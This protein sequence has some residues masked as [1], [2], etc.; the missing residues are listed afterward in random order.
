MG[1]APIRSD[2][3]PYKKKLGHRHTEKRPC[4]DTGGEGRV[5]QL[6][7]R[8]RRDQAN[9]W[10]LDFQTTELGENK[11]L[12]FNEPSLSYFVM[13]AMTNKCSDRALLGNPLCASHPA[14][15]TRM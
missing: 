7:R 15:S 13:A 4:E 9:T 8:L 6:T 14:P 2:W 12:P 3:G 11:F 1:E 10:V 5:P